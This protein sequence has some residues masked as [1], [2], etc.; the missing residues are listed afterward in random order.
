[1]GV[2]EMI[3]VLPLSLGGIVGCNDCEDTF[4]YY[5]AFKALFINREE[6]PINFW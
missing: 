3:I 2:V 1:M 4:G 5:G 6:L